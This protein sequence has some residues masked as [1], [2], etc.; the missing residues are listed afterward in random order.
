MIQNGKG[1]VLITNDGATIL[2]N[3]SVLHPTAKIVYLNLQ[4]LVETSKAQDIEAGDGTTSVVVLAGSMMSQCERL[5][6]M[7]IHPTAVSDGFAIALQ[8]S[9]QVLN[10]IATP[11]NIKD[12]E[13]L[14]QCVTTSLSSKVVSQNSQQLAPLAVDAVL[15]VCDPEKDK[16]VDL[17]NIKV[18]KKIGGTIDD[19]EVC[20]GILFADNKASHSAGGPTKVEKAKV[21]MIQFCLSAPKTDIDSNIVV[22]DYAKI[23]KVLKQERN[24]I[25]NLV[26]K[27]VDSGAN[28]LLVQ[29]S[30]LRD[31]VNDLSL[32]FLAKKKIMVV[33]DIERTDVDFICNVK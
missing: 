28:V 29:K 6:E 32:H 15:R 12:K 4:Q 1:E 9:L 24:Y 31:A 19:I 26:K 27:I 18:V 10:S 23:D 20:E 33:K 22:H 3:L 14:I 13:Q 11:I 5:L 7:G 21:A 17:N 2:K 25:I 30:V 16:T 8:K